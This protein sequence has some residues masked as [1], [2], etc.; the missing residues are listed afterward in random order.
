MA[1][2]QRDLEGFMT[3]NEKRA[4][5]RVASNDFHDYEV[6]V[7]D[8]KRTMDFTNLGKKTKSGLDASGTIFHFNS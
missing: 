2:E 1:R 3:W 7:A 4:R 8:L 5:D 6:N